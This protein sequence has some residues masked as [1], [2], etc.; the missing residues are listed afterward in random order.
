MQANRWT[1]RHFLAAC[2]LAPLALSGC[3]KSSD[4]DGQQGAD[5]REEKRIARDLFQIGL[6]LHNYHDSHGS[7]PAAGLFA[8]PP[9]K[10]PTRPPMIGSRPAVPLAPV[11]NG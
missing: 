3:G 10:A 2:G 9:G 6:A 1:R 8:P 5:T 4:K 7:F 11:E